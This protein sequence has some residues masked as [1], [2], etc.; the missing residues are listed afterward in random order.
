M[1]RIS[2]LA[3]FALL[4]IAISACASGP[5][6]VYPPIEGNWLYDYAA[7]LDETG[8]LPQ[9]PQ[10]WLSEL[11]PDVDETRDRLLVLMNPSEILAIEAAGK[12]LIIKGGG[13]FERVYVLDGTSPSPNVKVTL[14]EKSIVAVHTEP[15]LTLTET[16][17]VS[18]DGSTLVV[19]IRA[20]T[21]KLPKP[22]EIRR[23][24]RSSRTF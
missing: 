10:E 1:K 21:P 19:A 14:S 12:R 16:W 11:K 2:R 4:A 13:R 20:E 6:P 3:L 17:E 5:K 24:Y 7:S 23:I 22:I 15:E 18:P 8:E 9:L